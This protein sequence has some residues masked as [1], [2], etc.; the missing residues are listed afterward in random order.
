M[1]SSAT[2]PSRRRHEE[3]HDWFELALTALGNAKKTDAQV[4]WARSAIRAAASAQ[5]VGRLVKLIDGG[6]P[7]AGFEFDQEMRWA[8]TVK[9]IAYGLADGDRLLAEQAKRDPSDRGR[10]AMLQAEAARPAPELKQKTW[11]RINGAGYGSFHLTRAA[12][13][14]FFWADQNEVLEPYVDRFFGSV[15]E[16]F[17]DRDHP[18]ARAY[19][20]SLFPA[21]RADKSVL[22]RSRHL[23]SELTGHCRR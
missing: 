7:L 4:A 13:M 5:D 2:C 20:Q 12:M 9:A 19:I 17:E 22:D 15:R 11:E 1:T 10:R 6:E 18:F 3:A 14:G 23:L 21:Y 8:V 16:I